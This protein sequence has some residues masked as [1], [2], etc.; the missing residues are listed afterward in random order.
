[1]FF[2]GI[3][4]TFIHSVWAR[5]GHSWPTMPCYST[6]I[7]CILTYTWSLAPDKTSKQIWFNKEYAQLTPSSFYVSSDHIWNHLKEC[8]PE[9]GY[10]F[11]TSLFTWKD[12]KGWRYS[13][14]SFWED[15]WWTSVANIVRVKNRATME[16]EKNSLFKIWQIMES[17]VHIIYIAITSA[18]EKLNKILSWPGDTVQW[19]LVNQ[20]LT[21]RATE[22][23][24]KLSF[25]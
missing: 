2:F 20:Q 16:N 23:N 1:M 9:K 10:T 21:H 18:K 12:W 15:S 7:H 5:V 6:K 13:L 11:G 25:F 24:E 22:E 14:Q 17:D 3:L 4:L 19:P 8:L